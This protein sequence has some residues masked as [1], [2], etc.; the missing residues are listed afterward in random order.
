MESSSKPYFY[1]GL[2]MCVTTVTMVT[3]LHSSVSLLHFQHGKHDHL[4]C[5]YIK[6]IISI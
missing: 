5:M 4:P 6:D 1:H 2:D 3:L